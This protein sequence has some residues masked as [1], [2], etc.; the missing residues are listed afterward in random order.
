MA[1]PHPPPHPALRDNGDRGCVRGRDGMG[2]DGMGWG[3][4]VPCR[5]V[6][7][8]PPP[9]RR[10]SGL[11]VAAEAARCCR[12]GAPSGSR[13]A[14]WRDG[15]RPVLPSR[16]PPG[17][18]AGAGASLRSPRSRRGCGSR[19]GPERRDAVSRAHRAGAVRARALPEPP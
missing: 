19:D 11:A 8:P 5:A 4:A 18:V 14:G 2:R 12:R 17:G 6:P 1:L 15:C 9:S 10:P 3:G 13:R 16:S 7:R